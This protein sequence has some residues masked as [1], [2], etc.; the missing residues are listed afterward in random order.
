MST[1]ADTKV[2]VTFANRWQDGATLYEQGK[3]Y[4]VPKPLARH[5]LRVGKVRL[6][7]GAPKANRPKPADSTVATRPS[8][9]D[10][11]APAG[12]DK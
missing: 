12:T 11:P 10:K 7:D 9:T 3:T 8:V 4:D 6:S 1:R 2:R 5:L